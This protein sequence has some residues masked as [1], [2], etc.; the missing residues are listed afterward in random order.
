[1]AYTVPTA[2][3]LKARYPEFNSVADA[4]VTA[5]INEASAQVSTRWLERDY[6]PAIIHLTAHLLASEGE[7]ERTAEGSS[8]M[9]TQG[10][11]TRE[12][13][14][15]VSISYAGEGSSQRGSQA[16]ADDRTSTEYGR[17]F[18]RLLRVNFA[19]PMVA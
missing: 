4:L 19:G 3:N 5:V 15:A 17:R 8:T 12:Q 16:V 2:A 13:V 6:A 10:A 18:L 1:M 11:V 14:G 9:A 7:P